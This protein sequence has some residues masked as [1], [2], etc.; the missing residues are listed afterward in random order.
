MSPKWAMPSC[1]ARDVQTASL[2]E[3]IG[4]MSS[5]GETQPMIKSLCWYKET[6][7]RLS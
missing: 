2:T 6:H 4:D 1:R 7:H 3:D 5:I